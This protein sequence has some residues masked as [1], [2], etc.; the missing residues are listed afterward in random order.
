MHHEYLKPL[1]TYVPEHIVPVASATSRLKSQID[2]ADLG[3]IWDMIL[4]L[5]YGVDDPEDLSAD[6]RDEFLTVMSLLL[7]AFDR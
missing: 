7:A 1:E 4:K 6:K 5:D 3:M 2:G